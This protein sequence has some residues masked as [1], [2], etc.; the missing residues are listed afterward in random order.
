MRRRIC[1]AQSLAIGRPH[2]AEIVRCVESAFTKELCSGEYVFGFCRIID[3]LHK[4][5]GLR[6]F[7]PFI[8]RADRETLIDACFVLACFSFCS[9]L[10]VCFVVV[11]TRIDTA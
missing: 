7:D 11:R 3:C 6:F 8:P 4:D 5:A 2:R 9:N 1:V 10:L